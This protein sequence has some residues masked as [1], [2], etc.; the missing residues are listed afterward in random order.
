M[1]RN[2][3]FC[4]GDFQ[5]EPGE[6]KSGYILIGNGEFELPI[7]VLNGKKSGKTVLITAGITWSGICGNTIFHRTGRAFEN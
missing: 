7:T 1:E 6:K 5:V 4:L 2:K 3:T